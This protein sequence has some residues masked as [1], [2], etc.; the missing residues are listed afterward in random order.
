MKPAIV[1]VDDEWATRKSLG[2]QLKRHFGQEYDI[3]FASQ[4]EAALALCAEL[5]AE[6]RAIPLVISDQSM[7]GMEGDAFLIQLHRHYPK[8]LKIMLTGKA[9][10]EDVG[11]VVNLAQ[12]YRYIA[13]PWDET[14]LVLT[15][16]EALR[17]FRQEQQLVEQNQLLKT[18]NA[19]LESSLALLLATFEATADGILVLDTL[20][21]VVSFNQ[22][23]A[24]L[25]EL[26]SQD[27]TQDEHEL[28][29]A[30]AAALVPAD[31][32]VVRSLFWQNDHVKSGY[33][34]LQAGRILEYHLQPY[35]LDGAVV[36]RVWSFRDVTE[37]KQS[38]ALMAHQ[39]LH[40]ALTNLPN[41][42]LFRQ[43]C[44]ALLSELAQHD[45]K[46][47]V[48]FLDLDHFKEV[49]DTLGHAMGDRLLQG[50]VERLG[51]CLRKVDVLAR[52]GGDEFVLLLPYLEDRGDAGD[53]AQRLIATLAPTFWLDGHAVEVTA[54]VGIALYPDDG[55]DRAT[56]LQK[57]DMAMYA[58]KNSGRNTYRHCVTSAIS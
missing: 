13:K 29:H 34:S 21:K 53:V 11:N 31:A 20:G 28:L 38:A 26:S 58:A 4:G 43:T 40:D 22:K 9:D 18:M 45:H 56:L 2:S 42:I 36:G 48:M 32:D 39:A 37:E 47:A 50:V 57:A 51:Q 8:T 16:T 30:I 10:A 17:R 14:D 54:S 52:W 44:T 5:T 15:V 27:F 12:L 1:C 55:L 23:F 49:N 7:P 41:R 25:W 33:F 35:R 46:M 6:G 19:R 3:E 24:R